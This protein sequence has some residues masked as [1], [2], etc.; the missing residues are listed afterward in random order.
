MEMEKYNSKRDVL[1][2]AAL[3]TFSKR[4]LKIINVKQMRLEPTFESHSIETI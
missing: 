2:F 1:D 4:S 3:M